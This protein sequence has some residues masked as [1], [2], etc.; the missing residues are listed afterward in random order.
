MKSILIALLL[1]TFTFT[2]QAA[3]APAAKKGEAKEKTVSEAAVAT[4]KKL[5]PTEKTKL[6]ELLNKGDDAALQSLPGIGPA[7]AKGIVKARPFS[8]PADLV[9]VNGIGDAT[10]ADIVAHAK[11]GYPVA[12]KKK[13]EAKKK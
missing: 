5:T 12:E 2:L 8:D 11:A 13:T 1:S 9:K 10:L 7:K 4:A 3:D 6:L